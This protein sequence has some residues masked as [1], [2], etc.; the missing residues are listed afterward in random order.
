MKRL[1]DL[2]DSITA[3]LAGAAIGSLAVHL[4]LLVG[5]L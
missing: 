4:R 2:L 5:V 3:V 1:I